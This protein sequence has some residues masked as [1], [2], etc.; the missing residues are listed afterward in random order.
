MQ[1]VK[2]TIYKSGNFNNFL[3]QIV[4]VIKNVIALYMFFVQVIF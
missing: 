2:F 4:F 3:Q 1:S